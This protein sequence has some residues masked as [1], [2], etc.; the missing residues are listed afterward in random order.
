M[1][2]RGKDVSV[3]YLITNISVPK[4]SSFYT[5]VCSSLKN[6]RKLIYLLC[7]IFNTH[8]IIICLMF[9]GN[10]EMYYICTHS[11]SKETKIQFF[12]GY[13]KSRNA[14][15]RT[16]KGLLEQIGSTWIN[17]QIL[18]QALKRNFWST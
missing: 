16:F 4:S 11:S 13:M 7:V 2:H 12:K 9:F 3:S 14:W 18:R 8:Y 15:P 1:L 5:E 6:T 17:M 10:S